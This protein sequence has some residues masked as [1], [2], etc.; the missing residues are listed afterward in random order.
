MKLN[1]GLLVLAAA[2]ALGLAACNNST[3][4]ESEFV[5]VSQSQSEETSQTGET[6]SEQTSS[7]ETSSEEQS[8]EQ[9][10]S[11]ETSSEE[12]SSEQS[13]S[14]EQE[15]QLQFGEEATKAPDTWVYWADNNWCGSTVT[16][17][18]ATK[19]G[20]VLTFEYTVEGNCDWGFQVFHKNSSLNTGASYL[21]TAQ[22]NSQVAANHN[23]RLNGTYVDLVAGDNTVKV[24]YFEGG[25]TASSFAMIAGTSMGNNKFVI[26][27]YV[28][29]GI[30][31]APGNVAINDG[32]ITFTAVDGAA[33]YLVEYHDANT[34]AL[35]DSE[36]VAASGAALTKIASLADGNYVVRVIAMSSIDRD[37]DSL[38]SQDVPLKVGT[39]APVPAAGPKTNIVFGENGS[40]PLDTFVFW[41][42]QGWCGSNTTVTEAYTEEGTV[43]ATFTSTGA[44][45][46]SFQIFY[47]NSTL[48]PGVQYKLTFKVNVATAVTAMVHNSVQKELVAGDNTVED[49]FVQGAAKTASLTLSLPATDNTVVL[50]DFVWE[51]VA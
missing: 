19:K 43:H 23:F 7:E 17:T 6:S 2:F 5:P 22:I 3:A 31:D 18:T 36:E 49:T 10:S 27:N 28:W 29:E 12:Q 47:Y 44:C 11:E 9:A 16:M 32:V 30:L 1:K 25:S 45:A 46:F 13:S 41:N 34:D 14:E 8:S 20:K 40:L 33:K 48:T 4:S 24:K 50:S 35:V 42:D 38:P 15:E 39:D 37:H 26:S 21:L 51:V